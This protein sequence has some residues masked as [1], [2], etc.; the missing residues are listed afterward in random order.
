MTYLSP[1][2]SS[3]AQAAEDVALPAHKPW[4]EVDPP[5]GPIT[6]VG[7]RDG[8]QHPMQGSHSRFVASR[9]GHQGQR[10]E[11]ATRTGADRPEQR[12]SPTAGHAPHGRRD[13]FIRRPILDEH[14]NPAE[15]TSCGGGRNAPLM[16]TTPVRQAVRRARGRLDVAKLPECR[17]A[18]VKISARREGHDVTVVVDAGHGVRRRHVLGPIFSTGKAPFRRTAGCPKPIPQAALRRGVC[19]PRGAL[20]AVSALFHGDTG[21][22]EVPW[23]L[24]SPGRRRC[25]ADTHRSA[26][27]RGRRAPGASRSTCLVTPAF[28]ATLLLSR[29]GVGSS[30]AARLRWR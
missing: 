23:G 7:A 2:R 1:T 8:L 15:V 11:V 25:S 17:G 3:R 18:E 4:P 9:S 10:S 22:M 26:A 27:G 19:R 16:E 13:D 6:L 30:V 12:C 28:A 5:T 29:N 21:P 24:R 20:A 14:V